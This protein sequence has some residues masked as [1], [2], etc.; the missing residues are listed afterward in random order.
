MRRIVAAACAP[1]RTWLPLRPAMPQTAVII[2][3]GPAGLTAAY[4]LLERTDDRAGRARGER[5]DGRHRAHVNY[6]GNRI[7][8]GGH[9]FFS[10]SDRV[11]DWWLRFLPLQ[12]LPERRAADST[13]TY[14]NRWR[15]RRRRRCRP[16][17]RARGPRD[18]GARRASRGSTTARK[19]LR[20]P[21][22]ALARTRCASSA[23][24]A[25]SRIGFSLPAQRRLFPIKPEENL[26]EFFINRFG[27]ELYLTF[28]KSY[29]EKVWGVPCREISAEWG[30]QRIKGLSIAKALAHFVEERARGARCKGATSRRRGPRPRSSSSSSTPSSVPARCGTRWRA[31][32][33]EHGRRDAHR[34][35]RRGHR[36]RRR[37]RRR[38]AWRA[39]STTGETERFAGDYVLLDDAGPRAGARA[40]RAA[41]G[42]RRRDRRGSALPR[43]HH[44]RPAARPLAAHRAATAA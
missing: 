10:K 30:A 31:A 8:I 43:L 33:R 16:R 11:M 4:E 37:A 44:R 34:L 27:R 39:T 22:P 2:G 1:A 13:I 26:E 20:L 9:R 25:A 15:T 23:S 24:A 42:R 40:R 29:T 18:A 35:A 19:L 21:D 14:Q 36:D 12:A 7:D 32:V 38:R 17:S 41:A 3:A 6:K 28:F 5:A